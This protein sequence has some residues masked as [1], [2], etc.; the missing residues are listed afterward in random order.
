M[1]FISNAARKATSQNSKGGYLAIKRDKIGDKIRFKILSEE[2]LEFWEVW[3]APPDGGKDKPF[4]FVAQPNPSEIRAELGEYT[5]CFAFGSATD[6]RPPAF[7]L[8]MFVWDYE[9]EG[10]KVLQLTQKGL[11]NEIDMVSQTEE[12]AV[13]QDHDMQI[14]YKGKDNGW[15]SLMPLASKKG[16]EEQIKE[17]W[18]AANSADWSLQQLLVGGSPFGA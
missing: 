9:E 11:I 16:C 1:G 17:A 6:L 15:Y 5:Q 10:V 3:G 4:R 7:C 2:P 14:T 18:E 13:V 8:A 12:Y